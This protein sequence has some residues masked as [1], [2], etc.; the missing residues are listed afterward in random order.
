M[1]MNTKKSQYTIIAMLAEASYLYPLY[2]LISQGFKTAPENLIPFY[3]LLLIGLGAALLN[4]IISFNQPR[5]ITLGLVNLIAALATV[6]AAAYC[7]HLSHPFAWLDLLS[8][9][10]TGMWL[11]W[12]AWLITVLMLWVYTRAAIISAEEPSFRHAANR[13]EISMGVIF[14]VFLLG[15]ILSVELT[16]HLLAFLI[17]LAFNAGG[18]A[19][20]RT[21]ETRLRYYWPALS[22]FALFLVG[23]ALVVKLLMPFLS[24]GSQWLYNNSTPVLKNFFTRIFHLFLNKT[25]LLPEDNTPG[26]GVSLPSGSSPS[27]AGNAP[28][29]NPEWL[30]TAN[31]VLI[32]IG[33]IALSLLALVLIINLLGWLFKTRRSAPADRPSN[34]PYLLQFWFFLLDKIKQFFIQAEVLWWTYFPRSLS[35]NQAYRYLLYW[36]KRHN[37]P[38]EQYETPYEYCERLAHAHPQQRPHLESITL[39]YV[40]SYYGQTRNTLAEV[41]AA[42]KKLHFH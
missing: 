33:I 9:S 35:I 10:G 13:F 32:W 12:Q 4:I 3:G 6:L 11:S 5:L 34:H 25:H 38:R 26:A 18:L 37:L 36:G 42:L 23:I 17:C 29:V 20:A 24:A 14:S 28:A 31:S 21:G 16:E 19:L 41:Q 15:G 40:S 22:V 39:N 2:Y 27:G 30:Q 1:N 8:F 7:L